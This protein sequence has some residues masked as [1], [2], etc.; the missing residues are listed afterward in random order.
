L[1]TCFNAAVSFLKPDNG[2][3]IKVVL[4]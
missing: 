2:G 3:C 4:F 1:I